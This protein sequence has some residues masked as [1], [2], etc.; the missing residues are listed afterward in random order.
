[1]PEFILTRGALP[2]I[3]YQSLWGGGNCWI[4][5]DACVR[6]TPSTCKPMWG[7][8]FETRTPSRC[9]KLHQDDRA[10]KEKNQEH[11]KHSPRRSTAVNIIIIYL[12]RMLTTYALELY[13]CIYR[14]NIACLLAS[15]NH[16]WA[17]LNTA[18]QTGRVWQ[19]SARAPPPPLNTPRNVICNRCWKLSICTYVVNLCQHAFVEW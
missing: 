2:L 11:A 7:A 18:R 17:H 19:R 13:M 10:P 8:K 6:I 16:I 9:N 1:M 12:F 15:R 3:H 4:V 14:C 5:M